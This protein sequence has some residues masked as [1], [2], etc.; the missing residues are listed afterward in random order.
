MHINS[1][2][3]IFAICFFI[4]S[5]QCQGKQYALPVDLYLS[6]CGFPNKGTE[7]RKAFPSHDVI[8][9]LQ[10]RVWNVFK[11]LGII[12]VARYCSLP[13]TSFL[14]IC[15]KLLPSSPGDHTLMS[16]LT[17]SKY[18]NKIW[19]FNLQFALLNMHKCLFCRMIAGRPK[20][21]T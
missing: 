20:N 6:T 11:K 19:N 7:M 4:G 1:N 13:N 8:M 10:T 16:T 15:L 5:Y 21:Q 17:A 9:L 18:S 14:N 3:F 2:K 12:Y